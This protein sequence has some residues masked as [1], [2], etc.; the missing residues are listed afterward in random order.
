M[1]YVWKDFIESLD[2][3]ELLEVKQE[4]K[5][6]SMKIKHMI[7]EQIERKQRQHGQFCAT[8]FA[9]IKE[10]DNAFTLMFGPVSFRRK[11]SF[12]AT[13]CLKYFLASMNKKEA[14]QM[15]GIAEE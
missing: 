10:E 6:D 2:Y 3:G 4:L 12:C 9:E 5:K 11:A 14:K 8:C 13:D 1:E 7:A 15:H